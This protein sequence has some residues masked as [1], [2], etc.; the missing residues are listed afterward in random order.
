M[1]NFKSCD[2]TG[3]FLDSVNRRMM[4]GVLVEHIL[5]DFHNKLRSTHT[6]GSIVQHL[7]NF[8]LFQ[9]QITSIKNK[10]IMIF[11]ASMKANFKSDIIELTVVHRLFDFHDKSLP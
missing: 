4:T 3:W 7:F 2:R 8:V 6:L 9:L 10:F 5:L 1:I 11:Q